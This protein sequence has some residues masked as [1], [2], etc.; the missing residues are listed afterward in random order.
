MKLQFLVCAL[1][2]FFAAEQSSQAG[3][4]EGELLKIM[5]SRVRLHD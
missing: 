3:E 2:D 4:V 1:V 5:A